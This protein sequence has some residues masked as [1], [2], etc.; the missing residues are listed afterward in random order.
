[1]WHSV[2]NC[3]ILKLLLHGALANKPANILPCCSKH[4]MHSI[5]DLRWLKIRQKCENFVSDH[6]GN[7][8]SNQCAEVTWLPAASALVTLCQTALPASSLLSATQSVWHTVY[9]HSELV[10]PLP[11][12]V[13]VYANMIDRPNTYIWTVQQYVL[14]I[15]Q[16]S[17]A[18]SLIYFQQRDALQCAIQWMW[19]GDHLA[20][21][22]ICHVMF[23]RTFH[24]QGGTSDTKTN[25]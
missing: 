22:T 21:A 2:L 14:L 12:Q 18:K 10:V 9:E 8:Q 3:T 20:W 23:T 5:A 19:L 7:I 24:H 4:M 25:L 13:I 11:V 1:M 16:D 15:R 17:Q 6:E